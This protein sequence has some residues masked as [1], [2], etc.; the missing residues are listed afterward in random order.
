MLEGENMFDELTVVDIQKMQQELDYRTGELRQ[1]I[2][3]D[4][5]HA[6]EFG[7]LS[8]NAEYREARRAKGRNESR[9][10]YLQDMIRTAKIIEPNPDKNVVGIFDSV[11][12]LFEIDGEIETMTISTTLRR[13][14]G[15]GIIS[16]QSPLG[17]AVFG[18]RLGD[19]CYVELENGSGYYVQ[20]KG[21]KKGKDDDSLPIAKF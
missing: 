15:N 2:H 17:K 6:K 14:A 7:D 8:E 9:I 5:I 3:E 21:I 12:I 16:N 10:T 4:I 20:I 19:R 13:D 11:D 1:Q 18:K